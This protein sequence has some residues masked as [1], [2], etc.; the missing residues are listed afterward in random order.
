MQGSFTDTALD[1]VP[2]PGA[3]EQAR[4]DTLQERMEGV[5]MV[6]GKAASAGESGERKEEAPE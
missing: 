6:V 3:S 1:T 2:L 4:N 5:V